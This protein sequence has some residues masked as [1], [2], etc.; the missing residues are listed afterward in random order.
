MDLKPILLSLKQNK[1]IATIVILQVAITLAAVS[2][3]VFSTTLLLQDWNKPSGLDEQNLITSQ[4][5]FFAERPDMQSSIARDLEALSS[6]SDVKEVTVVNQ[7]PFEAVSISP[8]YKESG[9]EAQRYLAANFEFGTINALDVLGVELIAG[10][11]FSA[12]EFIMS[13]LNAD[14][15]YPSVV[16]IS[17]SLAS[18][19][20]G[21]ENALG[22]TLWPVQNSQP[23]EIIG[24]YSDFM[25]G[26]LLNGIGKP[27]NSMIRPMV[28]WSDFRFDPGFLIRAETGR[29]SGLLE[30]ARRAIYQQSGR[31]LHTNE[32][33]SRTKK[34]M[35]DGR[36]SQ[37]LV[38]MGVS[39][40]LVMISALGMAGLVS[41]L[42][43][44]RQKQ[45][46][47]RRALGARKADILRYF[48]AENSLLVL[49]GL[50]LGA[51][52][53]VVVA[54]YFP[55]LGS[56]EAFSSGW[57]LMVALFL[58]VISLAAVFRPAYKA[59]KVDPAKVIG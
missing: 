7:V 54:L 9:Q 47:I 46:G 30:D 5:Q 42:V 59:T 11:N 26:E 51:A 23:S 13:P 56:G 8:V 40:L 36:S 1:V 49:S 20:F 57:L 21:N 4:A 48:L 24:V 33:L 44:Q 16:M 6:L 2:H 50:L 17:E 35:Y 39:V 53:T 52:L 43:G 14:T 19:M 38:L 3:S 32:V 29:A 37:S 22:Q 15:T 28:L 18:E 25:T 27:Y 10:R 58:W 41:F 31:Y 34:R 45:I 12:N 55:V